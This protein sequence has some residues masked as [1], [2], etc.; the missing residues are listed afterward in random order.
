MNSIQQLIHLSMVP[1][2]VE[3]KA[4]LTQ[5]GL[6]EFLTLISKFAVRVT[7]W[8][9]MKRSTIEEIVHYLFYGLPQPF[10]VLR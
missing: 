6:H 5:P 9:S 10:E 1:T 2:I 7:I 8:S 3:P 4:V